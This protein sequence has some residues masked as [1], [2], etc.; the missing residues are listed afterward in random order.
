[1]QGEVSVCGGM[2]DKAAAAA[3]AAGV[4]VVADIPWATRRLRK[5]GASM[6]NIVVVNVLSRVTVPCPLLHATVTNRKAKEETWPP[7]WHPMR[8]HLPHLFQPS[9]CHMLQKVR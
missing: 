4:G 7:W 5:P 2:L 8:T 6:R 9:Q 3:A 1:M